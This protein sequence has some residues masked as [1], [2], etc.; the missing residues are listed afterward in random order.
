MSLC[1][2]EQKY[3]EAEV[4]ADF[5]KT[6]RQIGLILTQKQDLRKRFRRGV[7]KC[8]HQSCPVF[9]AKQVCY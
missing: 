5:L 1:D 9:A 2:L 8:K 7:G 3:V 4:L 6:V